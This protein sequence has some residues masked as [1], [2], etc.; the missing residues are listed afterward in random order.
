[1]TGREGSRYLGDE[2]L[3]RAG[4]PIQLLHDAN[5]GLGERDAHQ[6]RA[7]RQPPLLEG[8]SHAHN[9]PKRPDEE[10]ASKKGHPV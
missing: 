3:L 8:Q 7:K 2:R 4:T 9:D 6:P 5:Q 1:M 10:A